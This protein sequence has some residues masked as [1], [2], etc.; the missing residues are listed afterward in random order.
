MKEMGPMFARDGDNIVIKSSLVSGQ[1]PFEIIWTFNNEPVVWSNRKQPYNKPGS[2]GISIKNVCM[3]DEGFY[4]C[5]IKNSVGGTS[6][7]GTLVV[8]CKYKLI[9]EV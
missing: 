5:V 3:E 6:F 9:L 4:N 8:D 2:V 7:N 1:S